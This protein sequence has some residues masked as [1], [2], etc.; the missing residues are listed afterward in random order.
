MN[1]MTSKYY[2]SLI[3]LEKVEEDDLLPALFS[4]SLSTVVVTDS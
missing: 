4:G 1:A 2:V 3:G